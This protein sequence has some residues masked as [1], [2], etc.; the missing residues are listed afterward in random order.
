VSRL[1]LS[2]FT[3]FWQLL[4]LFGCC[5]G[6]GLGLRF[7]LPKELSLL[8]KFLFTLTGGF[9]LVVLIPQNLVYL[10]VPVRISAWLVLAAALSQVWWCRLKVIARMRAFCA[11]AELQALAVVAL[12]TIAFHG[13]SACLS[14][15]MLR[16]SPRGSAT[17]LAT[18]RFSLTAERSATWSSRCLRRS[19]MFP[20]ST[21]PILR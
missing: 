9:F 4:V 20:T 11:N 6:L 14:S 7:L 19:Q 8:P 16:C 1:L 5:S 17:T 2:I 13:V 10:G 12:L 3:L 18:T 21:T 15:R